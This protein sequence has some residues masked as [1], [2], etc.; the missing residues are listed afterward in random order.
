MM[1]W[2]PKVTKTP[3]VEVHGTMVTLVEVEPISTDNELGWLAVTKVARRSA[4]R[5]FFPSSQSKG[6]ALLINVE[7][8]DIIEGD[9]G[10]G[11]E[12]PG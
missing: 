4:S 3:V 1:K 11:P 2:V 6:F 9:Q 7:V 10:G 8:E 5:T 12:P